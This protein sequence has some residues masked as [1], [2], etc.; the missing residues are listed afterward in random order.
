MATGIDRFNE[1]Y[2][3]G[4][5]SGENKGKAVKNSEQ[6]DR[7]N[8][9]YEKSGAGYIAYK[10]YMENAAKLSQEIQSDYADRAGQWQ[11]AETLAQNKADTLAAFNQ[12][13][14]KDALLSYG[15]AISDPKQRRAYFDSILSVDDYKRNILQSHDDESAFYGQWKSDDEYKNSE[16]YFV[17]TYNDSLPDWEEKSK[18]EQKIF[19]TPKGIFSSETGDAYAYINNLPVDINQVNGFSVNG[20]R[21]Y[22]DAIND[23]SDN[24]DDS[25]YIYR[26][27][28]DDDILRYNYIFHTEGKDEADKFISSIQ[29]RLNYEFGTEVGKRVS[30]TTLGKIVMPFAQG[31]DQSIMGMKGLFA[32]GE[33][34][35]SPY[36]VAGERVR[37]SI[38]TF[39]V[40]GKD[41]GQVLY[42]LGVT[43]ANMLP[44]IMISSVIGGAIGAVNPLAGKIVSAAIGSIGMGA[45]AAGNARQEALRQGYTQEQAW[46]YGLTVG[47]L[48]GGLQFA[49]GGIGKLGGKASSV[50]LKKLGST[51]A[52]QAV[53]RYIANLSNGTLSAVLQAGGKLAGNMASEGFEE[54]LQDVINPLVRN[55]TLGEDNEWGLKNF[56]S[57]D[58]IY[59]GILG[60]LS[61][62]VLEGGSTVSGVYN[63]HKAG[64]AAL[65]S[66]VYKGAIDYAKLLDPECDAY[67]IA[68]ELQSGKRKENAANI[69]ALYEAVSEYIAESKKLVKKGKMTT[70]QYAGGVEALRQLADVRAGADA[71][72]A[73]QMKAAQPSSAEVQTAANAASAPVLDSAVYDAVRAVESNENSAV[74]AANIIARIESGN[75][76]ISAAELS[77]ISSPATKA[78]QILQQRTGIDMGTTASQARN[79]V[80]EYISQRSASVSQEN[81]NKRSA[82]LRGAKAQSA[83]V[84]NDLSASLGF[85]AGTVG[86]AGTE[87]YTNHYSALKTEQGQRYFNS[88][89]AKLYQA[90]M[91]GV[92]FKK[93]SG[94]PDLQGMSV[95]TQAEIYNAAAKDYQAV[96]Q[97]KAETKKAVH[98]RVREIRQRVREQKNGKVK[99]EYAEIDKKLL[100]KR[101]VKA[102]TF[103]IDERIDRAKLSGK[104]K[105]AVKYLKA[106]SEVAGVNVNIYSGVDQ[107]GAVTAENG[108]YD[109]QTNTIYVSVNAGMSS[110]N[111]FAE[112]AILRTASHEITHMI[113]ASG[114]ELYVDLRDYVIDTYVQEYGQNGLTERIL[115]IQERHREI[116][117]K[118]L[119]YE[120]AEEELVSSACEMMLKNSKAFEKLAKRN[121][122]LAQRVKSA[123]D[124]FISRAQ[125]MLSE[126][127]KGNSANSA[128]ARLMQASVERMEKLQQL[129]DRALLDAVGRETQGRENIKFSFAGTAAKNANLSLLA[130]AQIKIE[131]GENAETVR[132]ET[133][134]YKGYDGKWRF[135]IDDS[136][137][138]LKEKNITSGTAKIGDVLA[139]CELLKAYP[140]LKDITISARPMLLMGNTNGW[141]SAANHEIVLNSRFLENAQVNREL[142]ALYKTNEYKEYN[143]QMKK[144]ADERSAK[145]S[146]I[147]KEYQG[148]R[149]S[150]E[151]ADYTERWNKADDAD[152]KALMNRIEREWRV[153]EKGKRFYE[154]Q[155]QLKE[156]TEDRILETITDEFR[157]TETGKR[158]LELVRVSEGN[159][160]V[161]NEATKKVLLHE[162]QHAV[163][164][165]EEFA[166][167]ASE[168]F[169]IEQTKNAEREFKKADI[170]LDKKADSVL[171][172]LERYGFNEMKNND[173]YLLSE[174]GMDAAREFL[175]NMN[176]PREAAKLLDQLKEYQADYERAYE[177]FK[178][179]DKAAPMDLYTRTAGEIEARDAA[180]RLSYDMEKRRNTRPDIDQ[181]GVVFADGTSWLS[182]SSDDEVVFE[183]YSEY[184]EDMLKL[185]DQNI[186]AR[187]KK[188]V[189]EFVDE[190]FNNKQSKKSLHL[191]KVSDATLQRIYQKIDNLP[192]EKSG[193]LFKAGREYSLEIGQEDV[194]HLIQDK[195]GL[196]KNDV[197]DY[198]LNLPQIINTFDT[199][200]Y[201]V[202]QQGANKLNGLLFKKQFA[203]GQYIAMEVVSKKNSQ[204]QTHNIY[205]NRSDYGQKKK[206][207]KT[208]SVHSAQ[209]ATSET[210]ANPPSNNINIPNSDENVNKM[211]EL[212][213]NNVENK[214]QSATVDSVIKSKEFMRW[215]GDWQNDS[216]N[217]SKVVNEDGTPKVMYHG[218][219]WDNG[220]FWEFDSAQIKS[221]DNIGTFDKNNADIRYELRD[222]KTL[223]D[224]EM[225][226]GAL[227]TVAQ[228]DAE[229]VKLKAYKTAADGLSKKANELNAA[230]AEL[231]LID[232]K[233]NH[234]RFV[235][236]TIKTKQLQNQ[237]NIWDTRLVNLEAT[238][239]IKD[240]MARQ[241][242]ASKQAYLARIEQAKAEGRLKLSEKTKQQREEYYARLDKMRKK[243]EE[244]DRKHKNIAAITKKVKK[245]NEK[246]LKNAPDKHIPEEFKASVVELCRTFTDN[247][248]VFS[249]KKLDALKAAYDKIKTDDT[250]G[251]MFNE[252]VAAD[253]ELLKQTM[254]GKRL[255][256]LSVEETASLR[257]IVDHLYH[258][259]SNTNEMFVNGKRVN[260]E[261]TARSV[262]ADAQNS[263]FKRKQWL[264]GDGAAAKTAAAA[265]DWMFN[266]NTKP[267]YFFDRIGGTLKSLY[268]DL[269]KGQDVYG[270][271][272][273]EAEVFA[274]DM[275]KEYNRK[276]W[277][278]QRI[279]VRTESGVVLNVDVEEALSIYATYKRELLH[280]DTTGINHLSEGGVV[281]EKNTKVVEEG[282]DGKKKKELRIKGDPIKLTDSDIAE[283]LSKL[284]N[285]QIEYADKMVEYMSTTLAEFGNDA[286]MELYGIK[287]FNDEFYFPLNVDHSYLRDSFT[288][289]SEKFIKNAGMTKSLTK[290][291]SNPIILSAFT[292][293]WARHVETMLRYGAEVVPLENMNRVLNYADKTNGYVSVKK[294]I[295]NTYGSKAM[296]YIYQFMRDLNGG[297]RVDQSEGA[298]NKLISKFKKNAV[299]M[300]LSVAIQQPSALVRAMNMV[301][302]KYF[303][304]K[305]N[306][307][308]KTWEQLKKYAPVAYIKELGGFDTNVTASSAAQL[309]YMAPDT[310]KEKAKALF[311]RD[312][313][314]RD[315]VMGWLPQMADQITWCYI[316]DAVKNETAVKLHM[317]RNSEALLIAAGKRFAEV[318]DYTQVYDSV[319]A[320]SEVM[321]SKSGLINMATAFMAEPTTSYNMLMD[322]AMNV[323]KPGGGKKLVRAVSVFT[324]TAIFN[325]ILQSIISAARDDDDQTYEEKYLEAFVSNTLDGLNLMN[326]VPVLRDVVSIFDGY[327]VERTDMSL[328]GDFAKAVQTV[329]NED[330]S[331]Y[332]KVSGVAGAVGAFLGL[333]VKNVMRDMKAIWTVIENPPFNG[334]TTETGMI[335][336]VKD[337][338]ADTSLGKLLGS[339]SG[340]NVYDLLFES[341]MRGDKKGT[342]RYEEIIKQRG[343][344]EDQIRTELRKRLKDTEQVKQAYEARMRGDLASYKTAIAELTNMGFTQNDIILAINNYANDQKKAQ[345]NEDQNTEKKPEEAKSIYTKDVLYA[346]LERNDDSIGEIINAMIEEKTE[347]K[348]QEK[349]RSTVKSY[350]TAY[351]K[352][353]YQKAYLAGDTA[354]MSE[355][356]KALMAFRK[357]GIVYTANTLEGWRKNAKEDLAK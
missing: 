249:L 102:G 357:Y 318:I 42:D 319:F 347:E 6:V 248:S 229:R 138:T 78:R 163:Q 193:T 186:I 81:V 28:T 95:S 108:Y 251:G 146:E 39:D 332:D 176:A 266:K 272:R 10:K 76:K 32:E 187:S 279:S 144:A 121:L 218:T 205:M 161:N 301:D 20:Y 61:A 97:I 58:A 118:E 49:L 182:L 223:T 9:M 48:E 116:V 308:S 54:Y 250:L 68:S 13:G 268:M 269:R 293:V 196:S 241:R 346:A 120:Q 77:Y 83:A 96:N 60:A 136:E 113:K 303:L 11:S 305:P 110:V 295:E 330:K 302:F 149:N 147:V 324:A 150:K 164:Q 312:S 64:Q 158:Y 203:D 178:R 220:E 62:G 333:P 145:R 310:V 320:R 331:I 313:T 75:S 174:E 343:K 26:Y 67:Q 276:S 165:I 66:G 125:K 23:S 135:E 329:L 184:R 167:G 34:P 227:L 105:A 117:G 287:I 55:I 232:E 213:E 344:T 47:A 94:N 87:A 151:Y 63:A 281:Y 16:A 353:S 21:S 260:A 238:K 137:I 183:P 59:S 168:E 237:L 194:R 85:D 216:Q 235:E 314:Y 214:D 2:D 222:P 155:K 201:T 46:A 212:R 38:H 263:G 107:N 133:G 283:V 129:W 170:R 240:L 160:I 258:I 306:L 100:E 123:L 298:L 50:V 335:D 253:V 122:T 1:I 98:D 246:L 185:N 291:A 127:F 40:F 264:E 143:A 328:V 24:R 104:Q 326:L 72:R 199:V 119:T 74:K 175:E 140:Q 252:D 172:V 233:K 243:R 191:G 340:G 71:Q 228:N 106:L 126:A 236:L 315:N 270:V 188:D 8:A 321:R 204:L 141:F 51:S 159:D 70:D 215:F 217:A 130:Q 27:M 256:Q 111:A 5:K 219:S 30:S 336:A 226:A 53:S 265:V 300:S 261:V 242:E 322:A 209:D 103:T 7:F 14:N 355:I 192:K 124:A 88:A 115:D 244:L 142:E 286:S 82:E 198:V 208:M 247:S 349:M 179:L 350:I 262:M 162:L 86:S 231:N 181:K 128:E 296:P 80:K 348:D 299:L 221:T 25:L 257:D 202:Y 327:T 154:L 44:Y 234:E 132:Q 211:L 255:S 239:P 139:D 341:I 152:N 197:I 69:G 93:I 45:S 316:W 157:R 323:N 290:N 288:N 356:A 180:A 325:A 189:V 65:D 4:I 41:F 277:Q 338:F 345:Q 177:N 171:E 200:S 166:I 131:N 169:W 90:G 294:V 284:T 354:E 225:L 259:I 273:S 254:Q 309:A 317:D 280:R 31:W 285:E 334:K 57:E 79:A 109:P 342:Y 35:I 56:V 22:W 207:L 99:K 19:A 304:T 134:W 17:S 12:L 267:V 278:D 190:A 148:I 101:E 245:L 307:G 289:T 297:F 18:A 33:L 311:G 351:Y 339:E 84:N 43:T 292:D 275:Y 271:K 282:V 210:L 114:T 15:Y 224:R 37:D 36:A 73:Q 206:A 153:S 52:G 230:M 29:N 92:P 156:I 337:G 195:K 91:Q 173:F 112:S 89:F 3:N 352:E 274:Q